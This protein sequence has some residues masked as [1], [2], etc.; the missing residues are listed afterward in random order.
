MVEKN[1]NKRNTKNALLFNQLC[2][3]IADKFLRE[4]KNQ[5]GETVSQNVYAKSVGLSSSTISKIKHPKED[6][7]LPLST[8]YSIC[9]YEKYPLSRLFKE[10]EDKYGVDIPE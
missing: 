3:F 4:P 2:D 1:E 9:R 8:I 7:S 6:Y 10:F 5:K